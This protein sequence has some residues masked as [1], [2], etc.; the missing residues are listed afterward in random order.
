M[1]TGFLGT[2]QQN[3]LPFHI[4]YP[5]SMESFK[6]AL[7][8]NLFLEYYSKHSPHNVLLHPNPII[9]TFSFVFLH[10]IT[11]LSALNTTW[12]VIDVGMMHV[13]GFSTKWTSK[14]C[15]TRTIS[16]PKYY[17]DYPWQ[18][19]FL[20][21]K[22]WFQRGSQSS[23]GRGE[24]IIAGCVLSS[25]VSVIKV[26]P[27]PTTSLPNHIETSACMIDTAKGRS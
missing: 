24:H 13:R 21:S 6:Y 11:I 25:E 12:R 5:S 9:V 19:I 8:T 1:V 2:V 14:L 18:T 3:N 26:K 27:T 16:I 23:P 4:P 20:Y 17:K 7:K 10:R 22:N 15:T